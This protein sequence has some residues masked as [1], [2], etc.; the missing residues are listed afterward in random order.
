MPKAPS[1]SSSKDTRKGRSSCP[2]GRKAP[3]K[4]APAILDESNWGRLLKVPPGE[5]INK[6]AAKK[7]YRLRQ[8]SVEVRPG[9]RPVEW[10]AWRRH[11]GPDGFQA[12]LDKLRKRYAKSHPGKEFPVPRAYRPYVDILTPTPELVALK[13]KYIQKAHGDEWLWDTCSVKLFGHRNYGKL[14]VTAFRKLPSGLLGEAPEKGDY[15]GPKSTRRILARMSNRFPLEIEFYWSHD[16][17]SRIY[18]ALMRII[19]AHGTGSSRA[20]IFTYFKYRKWEGITIDGET[21]RD[22]AFGWLQGR[23]ADEGKIQLNFGMFVRTH[24]PPPIWAQY[25]ALL[26]TSA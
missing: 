1:S 9:L 20:L 15:G 22:D 5:K 3:P 10:M 25:N 18:R 23:L 13:G 11:G 8:T 21:V 7:L 6:D 16:Y 2:K 19:K 14:L 26:P 17:L 12:Y 4:K 24:K